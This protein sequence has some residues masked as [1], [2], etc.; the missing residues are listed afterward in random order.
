MFSDNMAEV[1]ADQAILTHRSADGMGTSS[2]SQPAI[3]AVMLGQLDA[4]PGDHV[5]EIG[6]GTGYN[7]A[8]LAHLVG[9][10]G[11]V[12]SIDLDPE[13][14][15]EAREHLA[16]AG[17]D[18]VEVVTADG[19]LGWP[20]GA[21]YDRLI[22]TCGPSDIPPAWWEQLR[23]GGVMVVPLTLAAGVA[24]SCA[25]QFQDG[26]FVARSLEPCGFMPLRGE[27]AADVL[28]GA[29]LAEGVHLS[30]TPDPGTDRE[31]IRRWFKRRPR[32]H[33]LPVEPDEQAF[34]RADVRLQLA[35]DRPYAAVLHV[36]GT[37]VQDPRWPLVQ[38]NGTGSG[39]WGSSFGYAGRDGLA[40]LGWS[41]A[42]P[43]ARLTVFGYGPDHEPQGRLVGL[44]EEWIEAG[45][46]AVAGLRLRAYPAGVEP[47]P[48]PGERVIRRR[49]CTLVLG[50]GVTV[51][52][53]SQ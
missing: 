49:S 21:P 26:V 33:R 19:G 42:F 24:R 39:A 43:A 38:R 52:A 47:V 18:R 23:P 8:L 31:A 1:Y 30:L 17:V 16:A 5:L 50:F 7:A 46:P 44:V 32:V 2:S 40:L 37:A 4:Q 28:G 3:M 25:F 22:V 51:A 9:P 10:S 34:W 41:P 35:T 6:A 20:D 15:A 48:E 14:A 12:V 53:G 27:Y 29:V 13:V 11:T 36:Q 45:R